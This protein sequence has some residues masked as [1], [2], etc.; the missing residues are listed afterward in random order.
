[1]HPAN[2]CRSLVV[3]IGATLPF[4]LATHLSATP[5]PPG[6]TTPIVTTGT[7]TVIEWDLPLDTDEKTGGIMVDLTGDGNRLWFVTRQALPRV[8]R[9]DLKY[10]KRVNPAQWVSWPLD[11][12]GGP[13]SGLRKMKTSKDKRFIFIRSSDTLQRVDTGSCAMQYTGLYANTTT[14]RRTVWRYDVTQPS[15]P[16]QTGFLADAGSDIAID[17][18]NFVYTASGMADG[19]PDVPPSDFAA[20]GFTASDFTP[21]PPTQYI[22]RMNPN[23]TKYNTVRWYVGGGAGECPAAVV[24]APCQSG[25]T[26]KNGNKDLVYYSEPSGGDGTG[27]IGELDTR[28]GTVRRW[29]FTQ[30]N[31]GATGAD[32]VSE[33]R[34][35]QFDSDGRLWAITGSGHLVSLDIK[36]NRMSKHTLPAHFDNDLFGIA[37]DGGFIGYT[38]SSTTQ[39]IV[40]MLIPVF[41]TVTV[42]PLCATVDRRV[43]T[44]PGETTD[45]PQKNG[46]AYPKAKTIDT[47]RTQKDDGT[48]VEGITAGLTNDS[49]SPMGI[50]PD[51]SAS[52]GTFFYAVGQPVD[53]TIKRVG[54]IRLPRAKDHARVERDDDDCDDDGKRADVDDD[55]DNDGIK[56]AIDADRDNDGIPDVMDDD[57]D[58][59]GIEDSFD[60]PDHKEAKQTSSQDI[61]AGDYALDQF[62]V[63]PGTLLA[64]LSATSS[65]LLASVSVEVLD[66]AGNVVASSVSAPGASVLTW[67]PPAAGGMFTLRVKNGGTALSTISTKIL[68]RELWPL[69]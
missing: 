20:S 15:D 10:G 41:N 23:T 55:N 54:R 18:Y 63:N 28:Y 25:V 48:F 13:T 40:G 67:T 36:R 16:S 4:V 61:A 8:Y 66:A 31:V 24:S 21:V 38:D 9:M 46:V 17:D 45:V 53:V 22:E 56:D 26:L 27:A 51:Y 1:M 44:K 14:C 42:Y 47:R 43:F 35:L 68:T 2:T 37:P 62:T 5:S 32:I 60:T 64:L 58:N 30:L 52:V 19:G 33:P 57:T 29:T 49:L 59:D 6:P 50:T 39:N 7:T 3:A 65:N 69:L 34:Q 11:A 12:T